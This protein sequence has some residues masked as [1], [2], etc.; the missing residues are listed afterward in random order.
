MTISTGTAPGTPIE[1]LQA[2]NGEI[3][4]SDQIADRIFRFSG[5]GTTYLGESS[6]PLDNV[7]GF[8]I[9]YGY[10]WVSNSG[11]TSGAPGDALVQLDMNLNLVAVHTVVGDPFDAQAFT[12]NGVP[13]L[14]IPDIAGD[15]LL[16]F[17]PA[18]PGTTTPFHL[19]DGVTGIDFPEQVQ[20]R[21]SNGNVLAGGF[22]DPDG[23]YEYDAATGTQLNFVD[24]GVLFGNGGLRG[25]YELGNGN[26]MYT[27]GSGV[28]IYDPGAGTSTQ[29]LASAGRFISKLGNSPISS[30]CAP[31]SNNSTGGPVTITGSLGSGV[32]SGLHLDATGGPT[33]EFGYFLV[34][35]AAETVSPLALSNGF[36][37][38]SLAPGEQLG[39]YNVSGGLANSVGQFDGAGGFANLVGTS[40]T[41]FGFDVPSV[42]PLPSSPTILA[43]DT[44][45][46][47][48]WYRDTPAGAGHSNLSNGLS[49]TF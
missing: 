37:C 26:I 12:F 8:E 3:W 36:L 46:F 25:V 2:P 45:H 22:T 41:G 24:T 32:G 31:A 23:I 47:Q 35:T 28:H 48:L 14:L 15:D 20:V 43:G 44:W 39:R 5:D 33:G 34:G 16:F 38:L 13:G 11:A 19:S 10:V 18:N 49:Y 9:A 6:V 17:D 30:F 1:A 4:I 7:R 27:S 29:V 40:T 42:V 21:A